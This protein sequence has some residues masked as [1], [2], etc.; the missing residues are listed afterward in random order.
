MEIEA[1]LQAISSPFRNAHAFGIEEMIDPRDT[2]PLFVEF[3][4]D[5]HRVIDTQLGPHKGLSYTP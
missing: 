1:K 2:R 4:Q 5:A 3:V